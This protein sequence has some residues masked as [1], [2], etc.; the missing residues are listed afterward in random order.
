MSKR[1]YDYKFLTSEFGRILVTFTK[2][3]MRIEEL[4]YREG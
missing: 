2:I 4:L 3:G 1:E